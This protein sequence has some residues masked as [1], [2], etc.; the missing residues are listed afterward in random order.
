MNSF[1]AKTL[2]FALLATL[3]LLIPESPDMSIRLLIL[4]HC[5]KALAFTFPKMIKIDVQVIGLPL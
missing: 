2:V 5:D 1:L 4:R 3:S